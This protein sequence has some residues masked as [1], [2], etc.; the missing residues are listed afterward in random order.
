[1]EHRFLQIQPQFQNGEKWMQLAE[2]CQLRFECLELST[3]SFLDCE[4]LSQE[5]RAWY[6]NTGRVS[7]VHGCFMDVNPGSGDEKFRN[8]SME[9][10]RES[11]RLAMTL[12]ARF[13][14]L[15][16][17]AFPFLRG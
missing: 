10:C 4:E 16:A 3:P 1:M 5:A 13:V 12:G 14:V 9:R 15:H 7:S 11:C 17:S 8:L 6:R 2:A